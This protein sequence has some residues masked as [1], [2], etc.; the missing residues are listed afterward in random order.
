MCSSDLYQSRI[1]SW[2]LEHSRIFLILYGYHISRIWDYAS[3]HGYPEPDCPE[4]LE[5]FLENPSEG[6]QEGIEVT[7]AILAQLREEASPAPVMGIYFPSNIELDDDMWNRGIVPKLQ[8]CY[9]GK[10]FARFNG[11]R[12]FL[13]LSKKAGIQGFSLKEA[14]WAGAPRDKINEKIFVPGGHFS[15]LGHQTV[16]NEIAKYLKRSMLDWKDRKST[17]LNSSH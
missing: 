17:R 8:H 5:L 2:L 14:L 15:E 1:R 3:V 12:L 4:E 6:W 16:A 7:G 10:S 13:E 9:P 11:E